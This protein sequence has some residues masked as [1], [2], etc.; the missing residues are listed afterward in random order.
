MRRTVAILVAFVAWGRVRRDKRAPMRV[1][2]RSVQPLSL[3]PGGRPE[4]KVASQPRL[5]APAS[6]L[7]FG[8][9]RR[10]WASARQGVAK[11]GTGMAPNRRPIRMTARRLAT[12]LALVLPVVALAA[13]ATAIATAGV[14]SALLFTTQPGGGD[15][16]APWA[17]QPV[18]TIVDADGHTVTSSHQAVQL[19]VVEGGVIA[20]CPT[21]QAIDGVAAF[22]GCEAFSGSGTFHLRAFAYGLP[23]VVS[24]AF[25]INQTAPPETPH[26]AF[27]FTLPVGQPYTATAG[28]PLWFTLSISVRDAAGAVATTGPASTTPVT[29]GIQPNW[30]GATITCTGGN[31]VAAVAGIATFAGCS[32]SQPGEGYVLTARADG[33]APL[34]GPTID[35]WPAGSP[36]GPAFDQLII[37]S[38]GRRVIDMNWG[39]SLSLSVRLTSTAPAQVLS[40]RVV[41]FLATQDPGDPETWQPIGSAPTDATGKAVLGGY[42]PASNLWYRAALDGAPDLGPALSGPHRM[43]VRQLV[44]LRPARTSWEVALARGTTITFTAMVR[45]ARAGEPMGTT[46]WQVIHVVGRTETLDSFLVVPDS[47]GR[48][49]LKVRFTSGTWRIQVRAL[50]TTNNANSYWAVDR[51][52]VP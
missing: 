17:Q 32:I 26:L 43:P 29:L 4:M 12:L 3:D 1:A 33:F 36:Q 27:D 28:G 42:T 20:G 49:T 22:A 44:T 21:T 6:V 23:T 51:Y 7:G 14:P 50:P 47:T 46:Q 19:S 24:A 9:P 38:D 5:G 37:L 52:R 2:R 34:Q 10:A 40:G 41:R 13:P 18:V 39:A 8:C 16:Y 11:G 31:T 30:E 15:E 35:V 48:A 25:T 45:P